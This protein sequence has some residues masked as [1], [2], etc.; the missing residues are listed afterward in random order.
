MSAL[1][2]AGKILCFPCAL[3]CSCAL[4]GGTVFLAQSAKVSTKAMRPLLQARLAPLRRLGDV[5]TTTTMG[6][7]VHLCKNMKCRR[8]RGRLGG[9][10]RLRHCDPHLRTHRLNAQS[11]A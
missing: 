1:Y 4:A 5:P 6:R 7:C 9:T 11:V 3:F 10:R 8:G 2:S